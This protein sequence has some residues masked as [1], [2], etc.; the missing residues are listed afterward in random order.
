MPRSRNS[1]MCA[2]LRETPDQNAHR[3]VLDHELAKE[4]RLENA[5]TPLRYGRRAATNRKCNK[6]RLLPKSQGQ[7]LRNLYEPLIRDLWAE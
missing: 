1:S 4:P 6:K 7:S 5:K 3:V 2:L